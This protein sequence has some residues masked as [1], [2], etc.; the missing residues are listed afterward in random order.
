M[1][2]PNICG[3]VWVCNSDGYVGQV[4][5]LSMIPEAQSKACLSVCSARIVCVA[6]VPGARLNSD[7]PRT[8][9]DRNNLHSFSQKKIKSSKSTSS[10]KQKKSVPSESD[11]DDI[12]HGAENIIAFDSSD[13]DDADMGT[14][15]IGLSTHFIDMLF[16]YMA[17][18]CAKHAKILRIYSVNSVLCFLFFKK[19]Q[20]L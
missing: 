2:Q 19:K 7:K 6:A 14:S 9:G 10:F 1:N 18:G 5:L 8:D 13:D 16:P 3:D 4:C 15:F 20:R 17:C 11:D 12:G